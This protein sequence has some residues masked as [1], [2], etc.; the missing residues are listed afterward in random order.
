MI[1]DTSAAVSLF[2]G[3]EKANGFLNSTEEIFLPL[4]V[5]GELYCGLRKC[6]MCPEKER[7]NIER[8]KSRTTLITLNEN[9][10][11]EYS[12]ISQKLE[13]KA[14]PIPTND[15]WIAPLLTRCPARKF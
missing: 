7:G 9:I 2:R 5:L 8:L 10:A 1:L 12:Q 4:V 6:L 15:I 14:T 3:S 11:Y 13:K